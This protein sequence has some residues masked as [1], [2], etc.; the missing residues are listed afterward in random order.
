[1]GCGVEPSVGFVGVSVGFGFM[2]LL[3]LID[4]LD[5]SGSLVIDLDVLAWAAETQ[6]RLSRLWLVRPGTGTPKHWE[7]LASSSRSYP[8][9][10]GLLGHVFEVLFDGLLRVMLFTPGIGVLLGHRDN[11][12][13]F[14]C[15]F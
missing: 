6:A 7:A 2:Y 10:S 4:P 15:T 5:C 11:P 9:A 12:L 1:M 13:S 14:G 8:A 3:G